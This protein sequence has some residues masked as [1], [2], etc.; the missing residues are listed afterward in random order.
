MNAQFSRDTD[1]VIRFEPYLGAMRE[2]ADV[3][4][5]PLF[6]RH[7]IMRHW[8][9]TGTLDARPLA[10]KLYDCLGRAMADFVAREASGSAAAASPGGRR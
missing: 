6:H 1:A 9:E 7:G 5:V 3:N 10:A 8:A 4:D 2:L